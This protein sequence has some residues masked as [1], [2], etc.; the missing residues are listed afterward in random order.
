MAFFIDDL[1]IREPAEVDHDAAVVGAEA[2]EGVAA[3]PDGQ[4]KPGAGGEPDPCLHVP[5]APGPQDMGRMTGSQ[6]RGA[7]R[8]VVRSARFDDVATEVTAEG[9]KR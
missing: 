3:A 4:R 6:E 8:F 1:H 9:F 2:R 5:D 7:S